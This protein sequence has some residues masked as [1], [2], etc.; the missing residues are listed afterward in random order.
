ML[1]GLFLLFML[2]NVLGLLRRRGLRPV[3][4]TF[5]SSFCQHQSRSQEL[6]HEPGGEGPRVLL[7]LL[8]AWLQALT[9]NRELGRAP[10]HK[11][12]TFG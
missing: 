5:F 1:G 7:A 3:S 2:E 11:P 6:A 9:T 8:F 10:Q 12:R 4:D